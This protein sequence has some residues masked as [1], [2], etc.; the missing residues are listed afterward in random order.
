M[1]VTTAFN[2]M[3]DLPGAWVRSVTFAPEGIVVGVSRRGR[4]HRC[5]CGFTTRARY[6]TSTRRWRH[7]DA[8]AC[9]L[10]LEADLARVECADCGRVRTEEVPWARPGARHTRDFENVVA[11]LCQ[12]SDKTT[13]STL[14]R[15]AWKTVD[16]IVVR[17]V[18]EHLDDSRLDDLFNLGVDEISYKRGHQYLSIIA[19][20]DT[21]NVVWVAEGR[22][23]QAL[24]G[25]FEALGPQ[26]CQ[27]V[28][29]ISMD[30]AT[31]WREPCNQFIPQ[32]DLCFDPFHVI[33]WTNKALDDVYKSAAREHGTG[34]GDREWRKMRYALRAGAERLDTTHQELLNKLRRT[35]YR[36][37]RAWELKEDLRALYR[38]IEPTD[39]RAYLTAWCTTALRSRIPELATLVRRI[40]KHLDGIIAAVEHGLSNSRLEGINSKVRLINR[41]AHG[42]RTAQALAANIYLCLGG[43]TIKLPTQT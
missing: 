15:C 2:R 3:L 12:R 28:Q 5:P 7:L 34:T 4:L 10:W 36:L 21:G 1:R 9:K 32:A 43:I 23:Q 42:H 24:T 35:R 11:W 17:V 20:H 8:A 37:W 27:Q 26:R 29:A 41:R 40:R 19:D 38:D 16:A 25:F 6:D 31:V 22:N 39:A 18:D 14:L 33:A 13:V 30:M